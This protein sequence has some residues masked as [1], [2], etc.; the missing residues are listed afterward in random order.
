MM[1]GAI[2]DSIAAAIA[3]RKWT[4]RCHHSVDELYIAWILSADVNTVYSITYNTRITHGHYL[5]YNYTV[6]MN[7]YRLVYLEKTARLA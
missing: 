2:E 4:A 5:M 1:S 6:A 3:P 7:T